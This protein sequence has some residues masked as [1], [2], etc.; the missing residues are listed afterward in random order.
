MS[1]LSRP[2]RNF[3]TLLEPFSGYPREYARHILNETGAPQHS[4]ARLVAFA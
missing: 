3:L 2:S 4:P 1:T